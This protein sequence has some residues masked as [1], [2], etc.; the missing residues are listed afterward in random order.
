MKKL[1]LCLLVAVALAS[2]GQKQPVVYLNGAEAVC[3]EFQPNYVGAS[4]QKRYM[5]LNDAQRFV[6]SVGCV[7][8]DIIYQG[9]VL[10]S[11]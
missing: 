5:P 10:S 9:V 4:W 3:V 8:Y 2:C 1:L 11:K 6:D 7:H